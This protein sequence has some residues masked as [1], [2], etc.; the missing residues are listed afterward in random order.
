[1]PETLFSFVLLIFFPSPLPFFFFVEGHFTRE[2]LPWS[3]MWSSQPRILKHICAELSTSWHFSGTCSLFLIPFS[4]R[5]VRGYPLRLSTVCRIIGAMGSH[6]AVV[7]S[8]DFSV[9]GC[10]NLRVAD[11]SVVPEV[12]AG[13]TQAVAY[14]VGYRCGKWIAKEQIL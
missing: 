2:I 9:R 4:L 1:M 8:E 11:L 7:S 14:L 3:S 12:V 13:N 6:D 10:N 5:I